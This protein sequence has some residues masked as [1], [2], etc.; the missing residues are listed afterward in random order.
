V[1]DKGKVKENEPQRKSWL[2]SRDALPG[3][4]TSWVPLW[5]LL[6]LP[7]FLLFIGPHPS[8]EGRGTAGLSSMVGRKVGQQ[9]GG[10]GG[11]EKINHFDVVDVQFKL[12]SHA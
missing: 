10:G 2:V 5:L 3:P 6:P 11:E 12:R 4:P 7:I 1:G 9:G 8:E